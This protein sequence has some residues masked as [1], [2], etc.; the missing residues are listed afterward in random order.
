MI[1]DP[2]GTVLALFLVFCRIGGCVLAMPGFSSAR[3]PGM[4]RVFVAGA[5]SIAVLP[6]LWDTVYPAVQQSGRD[7][8][9][10][11]LQRIAD[12]RDVRLAGASLHAR[13]SVRRQHHRHDGRIHVAGRGGYHRRFAGN[14]PFRFHHLRRNDDS[15]HHGLPSYRVPGAD[16]FLHDDALRRHCRYASQL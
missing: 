3:V 11:H 10:A 6:V 14:E 8:Y 4:L 16:R 1:T 13:P 15:L 9:R 5:L 7:L 12:R 2:Q